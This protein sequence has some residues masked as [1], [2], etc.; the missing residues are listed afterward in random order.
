LGLGDTKVARGPS[1]IVV[2][3]DHPR[4]RSALMHILDGHPVLEV[5][6]E[7][8]NGRQALELCRRLTPDLVLMDLCMPKLDGI[9]ATRAIRGEVP[10]T[11]VLILTALDESA[12]LSDFLEAD[13]AEKSGPGA[14]ATPASRRRSRPSAATP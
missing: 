8:A 5:V 4:F 13:A 14:S 12:G 9:A 2:A 3:D 7:A 6:A 11:R 10:D 1:R